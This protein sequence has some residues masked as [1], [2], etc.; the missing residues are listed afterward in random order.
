MMIQTEQYCKKG[1][2]SHT[3]EAVVSGRWSVV[4]IEGARHFESAGHLVCS[5]VL[6]VGSVGWI[7]EGTALNLCRL[8]LSYRYLNEKHKLKA[9]TRGHPGEDTFPWL[10]YF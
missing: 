10:T 8:W 2:L 6:N 3:E 7:G 4:G 9:G 1:A 5:I